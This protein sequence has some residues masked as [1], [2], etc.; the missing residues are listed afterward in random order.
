MADPGWEALGLHAW[1]TVAVLHGGP[2]P[3]KPDK[4]VLK[5][6]GAARL[7]KA[8]AMLRLATI[9]DARPIIGVEGAELILDRR[10]VE[11]MVADEKYLWRL[12]YLPWT[13]NGPSRAI[14]VW[15]QVRNADARDYYLVPI[16]NDGDHDGY[17][18]IAG[19]DRRVFNIFPFE[20]SYA[21]ATLRRGELRFKAYPDGI[22]CSTGCCQL[23]AKERRVAG[24]LR[25]EA[26]R[27]Q[28]ELRNARKALKASNLEQARLAVLT[29]NLR[30]EEK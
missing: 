6:D 14:E 8:L 9:E 30:G 7:D 22:Q 17:V 19:E 23:F 15:R 10:V 28:L 21:D 18:V 20:S 13:A 2:R 3:S 4:D 16:A 5:V 12:P 27:L 29:K 1:L 25:D 24:Q 11:K 26:R